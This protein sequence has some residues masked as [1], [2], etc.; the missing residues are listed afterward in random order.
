MLT[1]I[2]NLVVNFQADACSR[3]FNK[4]Q[5]SG[6]LRFNIGLHEAWGLADRAE[7]N[8]KILHPQNS[9]K[10]TA[11]IEDVPTK[12]ALDN[13]GFYAYGKAKKKEC[14]H[15]ELIDEFKHD[16]GY[17]HALLQNLICEHHDAKL[18]ITYY[19][20]VWYQFGLKAR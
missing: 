7:R 16:F 20:R 1:L 15:K 13:L 9:D 8:F 5:Q 6:L 19:A 14:F 11:F 17:E 10:L 3:K 18:L 12:V 2:F 4:S